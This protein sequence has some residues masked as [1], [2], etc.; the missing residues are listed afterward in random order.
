MKRRIRQEEGKEIW[1]ASRRMQTPGSPDLD[2]AWKQLSNRI[3]AMQGMDAKK[4]WT[5]GIPWR[6]ARPAYAVALASMVIALGV[7]TWQSLMSDVYKTG[8]QQR[9]SVVLPDGSTLQL[10]HDTR[11]SF[12]HG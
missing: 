7:F 6:V 11:V 8:R 3:Q 2:N 5:L 9:M 4:R 1:E 12:R 10:N